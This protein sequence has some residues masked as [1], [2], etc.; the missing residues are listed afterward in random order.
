[1]K[2]LF[3]FTLLLTCFT[4]ASQSFASDC[5]CTANPY[6]KTY[7]PNGVENTWY[8]GKRIWSCVYTCE[9]EAGIKDEFRGHHRD[10]YVGEDTGLWGICDGLVYV[11]EYNA[12]AQKFVWAFKR[13][14]TFDPVDSKS[15]QVKTWAKQNCH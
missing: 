9:N 5:S 14:G 11:Y 7:D 2:K 8:G 3:L 10:W 4:T 15:V 13:V 12:Y 6:T 1:M